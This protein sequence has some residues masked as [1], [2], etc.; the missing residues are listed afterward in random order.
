[1][2]S[3]AEKGL[4]GHESRQRLLRHGE[5]V[6][7]EAKKVSPWTMLLGQFQDFMVLTLLA[8][9]A[10][11]FFLG[12]VA[13]SVTIVAIVILNAILG[14]LQEYRA[15][16]SIEALRMLA[17]PTARVRRDGE[18]VK[19]PSR[20]LVPGD[21]VILE[22]GDR[23]PADLR[24]LEGNNLE[25]EES[26]L[27]GESI[28]VKKSPLICVREEAILGDRKNM[29][30]LGTTI[31]R[32]RGLG[33]AVATGMAT[34]MGQIAGLIQEVRTEETPLQRRLEQLGRY[35]VYGSFLLCGLVVFE[36]VLHGEPVHRMFLA[37][38]SLA[39]AAIPEGLPA[40]VTIALALGVQ[41]MAKKNAI[42][43]KL[44]A[45]E[46]LGCATA[47]C[48]DKTGTLT[49]NEMT[50]KR[51][52]LDN[53]FLAV[54][55]EGYTPKGEFYLAAEDLTPP[56][57][58]PRDGNTLPQRLRIGLTTRSHG[59]HWQPHSEN[60]A[61]EKAAQGAVAR[62][63][64][65]KVPLE[66]PLAQALTQT[67]QAAALCCN[68][69]LKREKGDGGLFRGRS[70]GEWSIEGDPTE[71]A[72]LV[73][74][75]KLGLRR[76]DLER[77]LRRVGEIPFEAERR[78]MSVICRAGRGEYYLFTKGAPDTVV[79][80]SSRALWGGKEVLLTTDIKRKIMEANEAMAQGALRILA[81]AYRTLASFSASEGEG[82]ERDLIFLGLLG[83]MDPPR[84][85]ARQAVARCHQAGLK[86]IMIT[87]DHRVT[88]AAVAAE[89]GILSAG[90]LVKTGEELDRMSDEVLTAQ[91]DDIYV[92]ARV[93]PRHK[94]RIVKALKRKGHIVAMTGDGV[95][96]APAVKEADIGVAMGRTGTD[97]TKEASAMV[98]G[99]DN[100]AT[101]VAAV[102]EGRAIYDNIRKFIRYLLSSNVG[103]I[104]V[105]FV[106]AVL[107]MPLPLLP[108]QIL[109]VNLVTDGLPAL[110]LGIDPG[111]PEVMRRA[112]R[113][114][115]ENIFA[116]GLGRRIMIRGFLIGGS[117]LAVFWLA[118][119]S[120]QGLVRARTMAFATLVMAQLIFVFGARSE[121]RTEYD[122]GFFSNRYLVGAVALSTLM[123]ALVLYHPALQDVFQTWPLD[124][125]EWL[126][127]LV[128]GG[129]GTIVI[130]LRR[131]LLFPGARVR[132]GQQRRKRR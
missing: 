50:V 87:G 29:A 52:F 114:P 38:V 24:L 53:T 80:L 85:E 22:A 77:Q 60:Y 104:M 76:E 79:E 95:N 119:S 90:G 46:T 107:G 63:T 32:G 23:V 56:H 116:R 40:I 61:G 1:M 35:L 112:P 33:V 109:W 128:A 71:G 25:A 94:L 124:L 123:L 129:L 42:I 110:A 106:A 115:G 54:T 39:V 118:L 82:I 4:T 31:T 122:M 69:H 96:D 58:I 51:I 91:A 92:Y 10:I 59:D 101:I 12:E 14:F 43:R 44:P 127:V 68:A 98:L 7:K 62:E 131:M 74:A 113:P 11:S 45:V 75:A 27:T 65:R 93:S 55:G 28:P 86:T 5:N 130:G 64:T 84:P 81:V 34:E 70:A 19:I 41:R 120:G 20:Q 3:D 97:V 17:A 18:E 15:E 121:T 105:M 26:S 73:V 67:L 48:S 103:E 13:D 37:G 111:D 8:A 99:D 126:V 89:L 47:I 30:F 36:G 9:T 2:G 125:T 132:R 21:L 49:K 102:E 78:R 16:K 88:A 108:I 72:L 83:M 6:L 117:T 57:P 66:K 100:F